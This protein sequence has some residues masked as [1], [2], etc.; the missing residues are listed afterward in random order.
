MTRQSVFNPF[1]VPCARQQ[2]GI[3]KFSLSIWTPWLMHETPNADAT[4][5][6]SLFDERGL[7]QDFVA[8]RLG[9]SPAAISKWVNGRSQLPMT[10]VQPLADIFMVSAEIILTAAT[11]TRATR[12]VL[13]SAAAG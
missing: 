1:R 6:R 10:R 2:S 4:T 11:H 12:F 7:R 8:K 5:F 13:K 3:C 9:V